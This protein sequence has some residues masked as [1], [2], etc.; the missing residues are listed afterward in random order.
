M[1]H[2]IQLILL[3]ELTLTLK[4]MNIYQHK[5]AKLSLLLLCFPNKMGRAIEN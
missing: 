1:A 4:T 2:E 5:L 3:M